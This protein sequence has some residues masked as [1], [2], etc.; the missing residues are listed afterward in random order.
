[1]KKL[2]I[3][4][5]LLLPFFVKAQSTSDADFCISRSTS[6]PITAATG[7]TYRGLHIN[8]SGTGKVGINI[9]AGTHDVHIVGCMI[10]NAQN[11][12]GGIFVGAGC[13]NIT[14]DTNFIA[15]SYRGVY[16]NK[17]GKTD[18]SMVNIHVN[19]NRFL[20]IAD[21]V[22]HPNGGGSSVQ[23][24]NVNGGGLQMNY[25]KTLTTIVSAEV[26][27]V[28][29]YFQTNGTASSWAQCIG[30]K[31]Q[32]GSTLT[33]G[34][35]GFILGDVGGSYQIGT[36]NIMVNSGAQGGQVQ[37]GSNIIMRRNKAYGAK[38]SYTYE[39][40]AYGNYSGNPSTNVTIDSNRANWTNKGG[41]RL[42]FWFDNSTVTKPTGW[43]S[44]VS[45]N[46]LST[47]LLPTPLFSTCSVIVSPPVIAYSPN[48]NSYIVGTAIANKTP[49][50]TG[51]AATSYS[52]SPSLSAGLSFSTSTG[53]ISGTPTATN[54]GTTYTI[55]A[56]NSGGSGSTTIGITVTSSL[57]VPSFTYSPSSNVY[58]VGTVITNKTPINSGG[59]V[60][61]Y[62]ITPTLPSGLSFNTTTGVISGTPTVTSPSTVYTVTG[63]NATGSNIYNLNIQ[64]NAAAVSV[65]VISYTSSTNTYTYGTTIAS[66]YPQNTGGAVVTWNISPALPSG[67]TFVNGLISG[68]PA[69]THAYQDYTITATNTAGTSTTH[70]YLTINPA[71]LLITADSKQ[72]RQGVA[73]PTLTVTYS[74]FKL[75]D[76]SSNITQ[77]TVSTTAVT[78]SP[79]GTYPIT[80][81]GAMSSNYIFTYI[82]GILIVGNGFSVT[83]RFGGIVRLSR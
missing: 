29:N 26:G 41:S 27:D 40:F 25:N 20:N 18:G 47:S 49:S 11:G 77:P 16:L 58:T 73:N 55:T 67:I 14:I 65:P 72:R 61:S 17:A 28:Y 46:T 60:T 63:S 66:L 70:V 79:N 50:N 59:A 42:D 71:N 53:V 5:S 33:D 81:S 56:T 45:D 7:Q 75:S 19:N 69:I 68:T 23:F 80:A 51:G 2:L 15:T 44:N 24:N 43:D 9:P 8:A 39:G 64:V 32:G 57:L 74:G 1:M 76:N 83:G 10:E 12:N 48:T 52:I 38:T 62:S 6:V 13:Y 21:A 78:G 30:N 35:S 4:I 54:P 37:G 22:G 34:K 36:D 31:I 3:L 82:N